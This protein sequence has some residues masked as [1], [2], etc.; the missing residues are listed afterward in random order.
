MH[1]IVLSHPHTPYATHLLPV[2]ITEKFSVMQQSMSLA[3]VRQLIDKMGGLQAVAALAGVGY[4]AAQKWQTKTGFPSDT[5]LLFRDEL[6]RR[7][8]LGNDEE[9]PASLWGMK[10][11]RASKRV[12]RGSH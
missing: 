9:P 4:D 12:P 2:L 10:V 7:G 5:Y 8:H 11:R 3:V 6:R 1:R